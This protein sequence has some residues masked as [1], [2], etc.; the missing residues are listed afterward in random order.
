MRHKFN[1]L[2]PGILLLSCLLSA[3]LQ[4]QSAQKFDL[5]SKEWSFVENKG[6]LPNADA[7]VKYYGRQGGVSLYCKPGML[8]FIFSKTVPDTETIKKNKIP[9][10]FVDPDKKIQPLL[11]SVTRA[12]MVLLNSNHAA[13]VITGKRQAYYENY[14]TACTP[15]EGITNVPTFKTITYLE[16]YPHIDMVLYTRPGGMKYEFMVHPGGNVA[17]I[18]LQWNGLRKMEQGEDGGI[19]Y[20]T[21]YGYLHESRPVSYFSDGLN[22]ITD[23][24]ISTNVVQFKTANTGVF[25]KDL[26]IDPGLVWG[27]YF[28]GDTADYGFGIAVD[29]TGNEVAI[30]GYTNTF[31]YPS[32]I[33]S[34]G[35]Y[36][37]TLAGNSDA[38]IASFTSSGSKNWSTYYGGNNY[39]Y[40]AAVSIDT[41]GYIYVSGRTY[42]ASGLGTSGSYQ[43]TG[44][45]GDAFIAKFTKS[46]KRV[47]GTYIEAGADAITN[48]LA[49]NIIVSGVNSYTNIAT[50]GAYQTST[51]GGTEDAFLCKFSS[52]GSL[53]WATYFG[54]DSVDYSTKVSCDTLGDIYITGQTYSKVGLASSGAY[55]TSFGGKDNGYGDAF[56]AKFSGSGALKWSSYFGGSKAE[57]CKSIAADRNGNVYIAGWTTSTSGIAS[58]GAFS[59]ALDLGIAI[60]QGWPDGFLAK[61]SSAGKWLWST[62]FGGNQADG[63]EALAIDGLGCPLVAGDT[64]SK[65]IATIGAFQSTYYNMVWGDIIARFHPDGTLGWCTYYSSTTGAVYISDM[66][67]HGKS[68]LYI[69]GYTDAYSGLATSGAYQSTYGGW[70]DAFIAKFKGFDNDAGARFINAPKG[71][72]CA[73]IIPVNVRIH[74]YGYAEMDS[75]RVILS[76]NKKIQSP[77][78]K[79]KGKLAPDSEISVSIGG[80][81]IPPGYDTLRAWTSKPNGITDSVPQNDSSIIQV[82]TVLAA[83]LPRA[84][85]KDSICTGDSIDIGQTAISGH[86]YAWSSFPAGLSSKSAVINVKPAS[87]TMYY[88]DETLTSTGCS[89]RDSALILVNPKPVAVFS[90]NSSS[91]CLRGNS[92]TFSDNSTISSGTINY[93]IWDFGDGTTSANQS[94]SHSYSKAG[95]Y[96]VFLGETSNRGCYGFITKSIY[97][98]PAP[99]AV[100]GLKTGGQCLRNNSFN[101]IDSSKA[102]SGKINSRKWDFG[103]GNASTA[104]NPVH[105]FSSAGTYIVKLRVVND[106]G[107]S[108]STIKTITVYPQPQTSFQANDSS[109]CLGSDNFIFTDNTSIASG[110]VLSWAWDFGDSAFSKAQNPVHVYKKTG[111]YVV[112]L[113]TTSNFGCVDSTVK[114][115][116]IHP[117]P[118]AAFTVK[119]SGQCLMGNNFAFID[120]SIVSQDSVTGWNWDFGDG[121]SSTV[122]NPSHTYSN[123]GIYSVTLTAISNSGCTGKVTHQLIVYPKP[124]VKFGINKSVQ[125]LSGNSF[126]FSDSSYGHSDSIISWKWNFGDGGI[127]KVQNPI[128]S[129]LDSGVYFVRLSTT[130]IHGCS[131]SIAQTIIVKG[132]ISPKV[133]GNKSPCLGSVDT[134]HS[135]GET[136]SQYHWN[137]SGGV[138]LSRFDSADIV[139]KWITSGGNSISATEINISGCSGTTTLSINILLPD[140]PVISGRATQCGV[141]NTSYQVPVIIGSSY[142]WQVHRGTVVSGQNTSK[143]LVHWDS[144][145]TG[146]LKVYEINNNGCQDSDILNVNVVV[147]VKSLFGFNTGCLGDPISFIDSSNGALSYTWDFGDNTG[148]TLKNPDHVFQTAGNH[149]VK[150]VITDTNGCSDSTTKTIIIL[151]LPK[152]KFA[153]NKDTGRTIHLKVIDPV[154]KN[155]SWTFGDGSG[156]VLQD[157]DHYYDKY[158]NYKIRLSETDNAG[159][160]G[161]TDTTLEITLGCDNNNI[162]FSPDP[163]ENQL[164]IRYSLCENS[165]ISLIVFDALGKKLLTLIDDQQQPGAYTYTYNSNY[166]PASGTYFFEFIINGKVTVKKLLKVK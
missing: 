141:G 62:Y 104:A 105:A 21:V 44:S 14:Y 38:F 102:G 3:R 30:S 35:A 72:F 61:F 121:K 22:V 153:I 65:G 107:C 78:Y 91:Q 144:L 24:K 120:Q 92:F 97:I 89:V 58:S 150:E 163:F 166:V 98:N 113:K 73:N 40:G 51:Y 161:E 157:P 128:H 26:T 63:I 20:E 7:D 117:Q 160:T 138:L 69:L 93:R 71:K 115:V 42:S 16:I 143:I 147:P 6:Q 48:D 146:I 80:Y 96:T 142:L 17:D 100:I 54:G 87:A 75:V 131:D 111:K 18:K 94:P 122:Q 162:L 23:Y 9:V 99:T 125:C 165:K 85:I 31:R 33:A 119:D 86:T 50:S 127:S 148:S 2:F 155:Y 79:W 70:S 19:Q 45:G 60:Y 114:N 64:R 25:N 135:Q 53:L 126:M 52:S 13:R 129:Y 118:S 47:W 158:G 67:Q 39:D 132:S 154:Y 136:G 133:T 15:E 28:G 29:R 68:E 34:A 81:Y 164:Y 134:Y 112:K 1:H 159:C 137:I 43:S 46:G 145:G 90:L 5:N 101:F 4:A 82:D 95:N 57:Q 11:V 110:S 59:T 130:T 41:A 27:T 151:P 77:V 12:D 32:Q 116:H 88:L 149:P 76:I 84:W 83:P 49:G 56:I 55:Q 139:V 74:N 106:S 10:D 140:K 37:T 8:S 36:Q 152:P 103:D 66:A 109:Q 123:P 124:S 108:D 156:S